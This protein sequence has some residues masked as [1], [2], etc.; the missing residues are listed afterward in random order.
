MDLHQ[1]ILS[2]QTEDKPILV[3]ISDRELLGYRSQIV[4]IYFSRHLNKMGIPGKIRAILD[5][6]EENNFIISE[7][8]VYRIAQNSVWKLI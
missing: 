7:E 3:P 2:L 5:W 4:K 1:K 8:Q 6:C